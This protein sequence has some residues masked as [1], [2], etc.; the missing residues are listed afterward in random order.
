MKRV[1]ITL[2]MLIGLSTTAFAEYKAN[3]WASWASVTQTSVTWTFPYK[4]REI[5]VHNGSSIPVC[6]AFN[7]ATITQSCT[8]PTG[9]GVNG[10]QTNDNRV[11]QLGANQIL[12]LQDFVVPSITLQSAGAAASPVSVIVTY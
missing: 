2:L 8:S 10:T 4:S 5:N 1:L 7:G 9:F 12:L 6:V 11:F 3:V